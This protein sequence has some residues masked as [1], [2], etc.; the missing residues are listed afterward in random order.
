MIPDGVPVLSKGRHRNPRRGGCFMEVA[1]YLAGERWSDH[2]QCTHP[3]LAAAARSV[4]DLTS[5]DERHRLAPLIPLVVGTNEPDPRWATELGLVAAQ[6]ALPHAPEREGK[7]LS[8]SALTAELLL[9][10]EDSRAIRE[11]YPRGVVEFRRRITP[12]LSGYAKRGAVHTAHVASLALAQR[13]DRDL[14][15]REYLENLL[16]YAADRRPHQD[17][18]AQRWVEACDLVGTR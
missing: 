2:P 10:R 15:L 12:T 13:E 7:V 4:N 18:P 17:V 11:R 9:A 8:L 5:N 6:L 14:R 16:Q 3:V 1:S